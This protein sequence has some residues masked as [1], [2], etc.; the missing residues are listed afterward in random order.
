MRGRG[1][2]C[3]A[4]FLAVLLALPGFAVQPSLRFQ[5]LYWPAF[6]EDV[7]A[8]APGGGFGD[9]LALAA[10]GSLLAFIRRDQADAPACSLSLYDLS[11]ARRLGTLPLGGDSW[12]DGWQ[13]GFWDQSG[14]LYTLH[15][16]ALQ[17]T[18]YQQALSE[19]LR[20]S[21]PEGYDAACPDPEGRALWG[22]GVDRPGLTRFSLP[23][24][25][26]RDFPAHLPE[27]WRFSG[28]AGSLPGG[29]VRCVFSGPDGRAVFFSADGAGQTRLTPVISGFAWTPDGQAYHPRAGEALLMPVPGEDRVL[30]LSGWRAGE[31][32]LLAQ[33]GLLLSEAYGSDP[34]LRVF[35]LERRR[36]TAALSALGGDA[37]LSF[38]RA[39]LSSL[40]FAVLADNQ[41][42]LNQYKLY[43]WD[44][45]QP[46]GAA[47]AQADETTL[48]GLRAAHDARAR[49]LEQKYGLALHIRQA[50]ARFEND[51][52][53][54][55]PP[56][57]EPLLGQAL[58]QLEKGLAL[59][60]PGL[61]KEAC[62]GEMPAIY[63]SG[64]IRPKTPD[65]LSAPRG[66]APLSGGGRYIVLDIGMM[67]SAHTLIHEV[68]HLLEDRL[69]LPAAPGRR[70]MLGDWLLLSP[71][72]VPDG[73]YFYSYHDENGREISDT[74][75]TADAPD[76]LE[77]PAGIWFIDAYSRTYPMEDRARILETLCL[78]DEAPPEVM[79]S[80]RLLRKAQY[81][82][83]MLREG[84][85]SLRDVPLLPWERHLPRIPYEVFRREFEAA[86]PGNP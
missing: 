7:Y 79:N 25:E 15:E 35:D 17:L 40:G 1:R 53:Y 47:S 81:L 19:T 22:A 6:Q 48:T 5:A 13:L 29:G 23:D 77:S 85:S 86:G 75:L 56:D 16:G 32:I 45:R 49:E 70:D 36:F 11:S 68:M 64:G 41:Y 57:Q 12:F 55:L 3:L 83:A 4:A 65:G 69:A 30:R 33:G 14:G 82:C 26:A 66:F 74:A 54:A 31:Y 84:F 18:L 50:G 39:A 72:G 34:A 44:F 71:P 62:G 51:D 76:A 10:Q 42:E 37:S 46:S 67:D 78:A 9:Y 59:L 8:L 60:P 43:L 61:L 2:I 38:D 63:L 24:G 27:G 73:G 21:L 20:F 28:F 52:Y 80:P 58:D